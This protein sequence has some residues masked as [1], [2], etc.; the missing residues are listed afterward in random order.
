MKRILLIIIPLLALAGIWYVSTQ[1][2][3]KDKSSQTDALEEDAEGNPDQADGKAPANLQGDTD[4]TEAPGGETPGVRKRVAEITAEEPEEVQ[5]LKEGERWLEGQITWPMGHQPEGSVVVYALAKSVDRT[6]LDSA[7]AGKRESS[8]QINTSMGPTPTMGGSFANVVLAKTNMRPDGT[9]RIGVPDWRPVHLQVLGK[10]LYRK[11]AFDVPSDLSNAKVTLEA[12]L[13]AFVYGK[14]SLTLPEA[15]E[16]P[17]PNFDGLVKVHSELAL[18]EAMVN[19][20]SAERGNY[21]CEADETGA[22]ELHGLPASAELVLRAEPENHS[23]TLHS[24]GETTMGASYEVDLQLDLGRT[25]RGKVVDGSGQGIVA[26]TVRVY[27]DDGPGSIQQDNLSKGTSDDQGH[28]EIANLPNVDLLLHAR[29]EGWLSMPATKTPLETDE[30]EWVLTMDAGLSLSGIVLFE[31]GSPAA[32]IE[33]EGHLDIAHLAP[34]ENMSIMRYLYTSPA[35][36]SDGQGRFELKG[37]SPLAYAFSASTEMEGVTLVAHAESV[38][39]KQG[40]LT[41]TLIPKPRVQGQ[42]LMPDGEPLEAYTLLVR[43]MQKGQAYT[44]YVDEKIVRIA[45]PE[46]RFEV[47]DLQQ[48]SWQIQ[49]QSERFL[50]SPFVEVEL[51]RPADADEL[52]LTTQAALWIDGHVVKPAGTPVQGARISPYSQSLTAIPQLEKSGM[53]R[54]IRSLEDGSFSLGPVPAGQHN[55]RATHEDYC[56]SEPIEV[57]LSNGPPTRPIVLQLR[58]GATLTGEVFKKGWKLASWG[59][60]SG[61][62]QQVRLGLQRHPNGRQGP[63]SSGKPDSRQVPN[64]RYG[65]P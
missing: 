22:F 7:L 16:I 3:S 23:Q 51:P 9:F 2:D 1:S 8:R 52:V 26:A 38:R 32:D 18:D 55:L 17:S 65:P 49:V 30:T 11:R 61:H 37:L 20:D 33:V 44:T 54:D 60:D 64:H 56:P 63:I 42:V 35:A 5:V 36:V 14:M 46:G 24:V 12:E 41:L 45:D 15:E 43:R 50:L 59:H 27:R 29:H 4:L 31:D 28:F 19:P 53:D 58:Q 48:G 21:F 6:E 62:E 47:E 57:D 39:A 13:G 40:E 25:L 10:H 34:M